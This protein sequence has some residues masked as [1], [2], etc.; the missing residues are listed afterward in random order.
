MSRPP[1]TRDGLTNGEKPVDGDGASREGR[2]TEVLPSLED[3]AAYPRANTQEPSPRSARRGRA[4]TRKE[5][6][7]DLIR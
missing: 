4:Y 5:F 1:D 6:D 7:D 2:G 3:D